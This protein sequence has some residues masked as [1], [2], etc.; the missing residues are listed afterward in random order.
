V[1]R[2]LKHG[3]RLGEVF[4]W[5]V[6]ATSAG[7]RMERSV[8]LGLSQT[9]A[10][11][12]ADR[13][14][15]VRTGA[16][17]PEYDDLSRGALRVAAPALDGGTIHRGGGLPLSYFGFKGKT[18]AAGVRAVKGAARRGL[19]G[20]GATDAMGDSEGTHEEAEEHGGGS[21]LG[22]LA[23]EAAAQAASAEGRSAIAAADRARRWERLRQDS[24][25]GCLLAPWTVPEPSPLSPALL[26]ARVQ[27]EAD[28]SATAG[29]PHVLAETEVML[30]RVPT[31]MTTTRM[32]AAAAIGAADEPAEKPA[33]RRSAEGA[34]SGAGATPLLPGPDLA[35]ESRILGAAAAGADSA[36]P[37]GRRRAALGLPVQIH[38]RDAFPL[39]VEL[40]RLSRR[41]ICAQRFGGDDCERAVEEFRQSMRA[42]AL[43]AEADEALAGALQEPSEVPWAWEGGGDGGAAGAGANEG[44][45]R[46]TDLIEATGRVVRVR[47]VGSSGAVVEVKLTGPPVTTALAPRRP[48]ELAFVGEDVSLSAE[49]AE[50]AAE[51]RTRAVRTGTSAPQ[52]PP[53]DGREM[54]TASLI[55]RAAPDPE[56]T[57]DA[58]EARAKG[59]RQPWA[60]AGRVVGG[61]HRF[62]PGTAAAVRRL[63]MQGRVALALVLMGSLEASLGLAVSRGRAAVSRRRVADLASRLLHGDGETGRGALR[64]GLEATD[65]EAAVEAAARLRRA[66]RRGMRRGDGSGSG[67]GQGPGG[68]GPLTVMTS[69]EAARCRGELRAAVSR[70]LTGPAANAAAAEAAEAVWRLRAREEGAAEAL[71]SLLAESGPLQDATASAAATGDATRA[72]VARTPARYRRGGQAPSPV[73]RAQGSLPALHARSPTALAGAGSRPGS[74]STAAVIRDGSASRHMWNSRAVA[75]ARRAGG[76]SGSGEASASRGERLRAAASL[77]R[78]VTAYE[79]AAARAEPEPEDGG[80]GRRQ[81]AILAEAPRQVPAELSEAELMAIHSSQAHQGGDGEED[82]EATLLEIGLGM[83]R[84]ALTLNALKR[85]QATAELFRSDEPLQ[86]QERARRPD[87]TSLPPAAAGGKQRHQDGPVPSSGGYGG[88]LGGASPGVRLVCDL[89][90]ARRAAAEATPLSLPLREGLAIALRRQEARRKA[91][92]GRPVSAASSLSSAAPPASHEALMDSLAAARAQLAGEVAAGLASRLG[93]LQAVLEMPLR[94]STTVQ[95]QPLPEAGAAGALSAGAAAGVEGVDHS[96]RGGETIRRGRWRQNLEAWED[97]ATVSGALAATFGAAV[98]ATAQ[99]DGIRAARRRTDVLTDPAVRR[100]MSLPEQLDGGGGQAPRGAGGLSPSLPPGSPMRRPALGARSTVGLPAVLSPE[101]AGLVRPRSRAESAVSSATSLSAGSRRAPARLGSGDGPSSMPR[102]PGTADPVEVIMPRRGQG[103]ARPMT[104]AEPQRGGNGFRGVGAA[105]SSAGSRPV[106]EGGRSAH[107]SHEASRYDLAS[108]FAPRLGASESRAA[109][110]AREA[111][112][113]GAVEAALARARLLGRLPVPRLQAH[114]ADPALAWVTLQAWLASA[115]QLAFSEFRRCLERVEALVGAELSRAVKFQGVPLAE[116]ERLARPQAGPADPA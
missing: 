12:E 41:A 13:V 95:S 2:A 68:P 34:P 46:S 24:V 28:G 5:D 52:P 53:A 94:V 57:A 26:R 77:R 21:A 45:R 97:L 62:S 100:A 82:D 16:H 92:A 111:A 73:R 44:P 37:P 69:S 19:R 107:G 1:R 113:P 14:T 42:V 83:P 51:G 49:A 47:L 56:V 10:K 86:P 29:M 90:A 70:E 27:A 33:A 55:G 7:R 54:E 11:L 87:E 105:S 20:L 58:E 63:P 79:A 74:A 76:V 17:R 88:A 36:T 18:D 93:A 4:G 91:M 99:A 85:L 112:V 96:P 80:A 30:C 108:R 22:G 72:R 59:V 65:A 89:D 40:Y 115:H 48:E 60:A 109:A 81:A 6:R 103:A 106:S 35:T 32:G 102:Q 8:L 75:R 25:L 67:L 9:G 61:F 101:E 71:L 110:H 98:A 39:D 3:V 64:D 116:W 66:Q 43:R 78:F 15:G 23:A 114:R 31:S 38:P 50:A 84:K 104:S